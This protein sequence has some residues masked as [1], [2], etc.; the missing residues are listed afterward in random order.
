ML[1]LEM[2]AIPTSDLPGHQ[3]LHQ[4]TN[5]ALETC[6][7][8]QGVDFKES[9]A[10]EA[11]KWRVIKS[12]LGMGNLRDGGIIVIGV[13]ER[14]GSWN[15]EG[16]SSDHLTTYNVDTVIDQINAY[17]SPSVEID[18]V[19]VRDKA[20]KIFLTIQ[21]EEFSETPLV[22]KKN[23]PDGMGLVEGATF[24]RPP[25]MAKTTKITNASQMHELLELAAEKRARRILEVSRRVGLVPS[26]SSK[27]LFDKELEGL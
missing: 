19:S 8:S 1:P 20:G 25:G 9:A 6:Q 11:L 7:E 22:C 15:L 27:E 21:V 3:R 16:I 2:G 24:I 5:S 18:I 26:E 12:V 14:G 13:S 17:I 4:R 23:G 10:W